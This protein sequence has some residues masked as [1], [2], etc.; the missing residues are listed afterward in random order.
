MNKAK[1]KHHMFSWLN[2]IETLVRFQDVMNVIIIISGIFLALST[3]FSILSGRKI[4]GLKSYNKLNWGIHLSGVGTTC[5][6]S[7]FFLPRIPFFI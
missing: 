1:G 6:N 4:S 5:S 3:M 2:S 7:P